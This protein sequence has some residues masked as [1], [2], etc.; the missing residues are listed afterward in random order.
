[1]KEKT[2]NIVCSGVA[3]TTTLLQTQ[4]IFQLICLILTA[5]STAI[6]IA[7]NLYK[8]FIKSNQDTQITI[9]EIEQGINILNHGLKKLESLKKKKEDDNNG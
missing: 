5:I 1:M 7:F 4:Q 8:W 3:V 9:E 2:I 6:I